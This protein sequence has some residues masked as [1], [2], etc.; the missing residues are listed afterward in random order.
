MSSNFVDRLS[1]L[2]RL[3]REGLDDAMALIQ[4]LLGRE[5]RSAPRAA[6]G[7]AAYAP[8]LPAYM[9]EAP[10]P[11]PRRM[12]LGETIGHLVERPR[13]PDPEPEAE[14]APEAPPE[15]V[16]AP[17]GAR[18]EAG[19]FADSAGSARNYKLYVPAA[20]A[21]TGLRPLVLMLHGCGQ[22]PDDFARG[23]GM[24][25]AA[26]DE[27]VI[28][29]YPE[30]PSG[31]NPKRCWNWFRQDDASKD[32]G[33]TALLVEMTRHVLATENVDPARVYVAG[34]S[35]GGAQAM[36]LASHHRD[37]FAAAGVHSG[38]ASGAARDIPSAFAAMNQGAAGA[39]GIRPLRTIVFHGDADKTVHPSNATAVTVQA[40]AGAGPLELEVEHGEARGRVYSRARHRDPAGATL[41]ETWTL[42]GAGHAWSGGDP[43]GSYADASGPDATRE[44]LRF[45]LRG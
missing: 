44:M 8:P 33:E 17:V 6:E 30:Q 4:R 23:A 40:T 19:R 7:A 32:G 5:T 16:A 1:G 15:P 2:A 26:E 18:F 41:C 34:L 39:E 35:A 31:A 14:A 11:L 29:L 38:L 37:L 36:N 13:L 24:N 21:G 12:G 25:A 20:G 10:A 22:D 42:H 28:V 3:T 45:F 9:P 43:A 27:G